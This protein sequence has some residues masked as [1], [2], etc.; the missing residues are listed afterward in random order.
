[1]EPH[2]E[3]LL[4][5]SADDRAVL[6]HLLPPAILGLHAQRACEKRLKALL[7]QLGH[8]YPRTYNLGALEELVELR[9][10]TLPPLA[11]PL[12]RLNDYAVPYRYDDLPL[13]FQVDVVALRR[14][15]DALRVHVEGRLQALAAPAAG[16]SIQDAGH[17]PESRGQGL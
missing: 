7:I 8:D 13:G 15:V 10:Q 14:T 1:M 11:L 17:R 16:E 6:D 5:K 3:M 12:Y 4:R 2:A 9:D